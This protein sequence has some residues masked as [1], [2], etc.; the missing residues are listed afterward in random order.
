MTNSIAELEKDS[1]CIFVIGSNPTDNHPVIGMKIKKNVLYNGAKLIVADARYTD[2][3]SIADVYLPHLPGTDVALLNAMI[4]VIISENLAD[5]AF[6]AEH[7]EGYEEMAKVVANYTP[8]YAETI[9]GVPAE[10]I[11][12]AARLY[13]ESGPA[14]ICY[15]MGLTQHSTGT[16]NVKSVCNLAMVTGNIGRPGTGVDPLRGQNNVQ[17]ACDMGGLPNV[18]TGY[19]QVANETARAKFEEA[20]GVKLPDKNGITLTETINKAHDGD[21]K[22]LFVL[23]ENP[24]MSD[25]D[26]N[27]VESAL[28]HLEFLVVQDIF[29]TETAQLA[30]VVLPGACFAEKD[31]TF[32]NTER[33][34]QRVRKAVNPPGQ[35]RTDWEILCDLAA[36]MGYTMNYSSSQDIFEEISGLTPSYAGMS[37]DRLEGKGLQWPCPTPE[38]PGTVFLHKDGN[39]SR[40]KGA[41]S[42]IEYK[43]PYEEPDQEYPVILTTGRS[44]FHYHTGTMTRRC[45]ALDEHV[46]EAELEIHPELAGKLNI[47]EGEMV[48]LST[49]RGSIEIKAKVTDRIA[50]NVV[51]MPFH[52]AEAAA[53]LL[54]HAELLD[55][56]AKIP[57]YK[58][59]AARIEK[60]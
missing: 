20:W 44:L 7:T 31:G 8:E 56:V 3:A 54:T 42:A 15:A 43:A 37:Y 1:R 2:L 33:R 30:D 36:R 38:H 6:I 53:N 24:M 50:P 17:G 26:L 47:A 52:F 40:G 14:A 45:K 16:D 48:R 4:N 5:Q 60:I 35:A 23:G 41:F 58:V 12:K 25:P 51:F 55:P 46:P 21:I 32:S 27:H 9:T 10:D 57:E 28:K 19:Q 29:L 34:V 11:R 49:R 39:F 13:A 18:F 59:S 22:A